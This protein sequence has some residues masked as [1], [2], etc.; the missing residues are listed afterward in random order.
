MSTFNFDVIVVGDSNV[1]KTTY[2]NR[3]ASG[4]FTNKPIKTT[5]KNLYPISFNVYS[6]KNK[7]IKNIIFNCWDLD[8]D[9]I[10]DHGGA[11][12]AIIM[13]DVTVPESYNELNFLYERMTKI[14]GDIAFV[15][16]GN[17]VD[18]KDRKVKAT[19]ISS[20]DNNNMKYYDISAKSNYNY[21]KPFLSLARE[22]TG[23]PDLVFRCSDVVTP[24]EVTLQQSPMLPPSESEIKAEVMK[25]IKL[26]FNFSE[27]QM[28]KYDLIFSRTSEKLSE[29]NK[30]FVVAIAHHEK[31]DVC[32]SSLDVKVFPNKKEYIEYRS[33]WLVDK[34]SCYE[35]NI[36]DCTKLMNMINAILEYNILSG[37]LIRYNVEKDCF[38]DFEDSNRP[39]AVI[40]FN[41]IDIVIHKNI[42]KICEETSIVEMMIK[43][44]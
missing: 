8:E 28:K 31:G 42:I 34:I 44:V 24:P 38:G 26:R 43:E 4:E 40:C 14:Y 7:H 3:L 12:G 39:E 19:N 18:L 16:C 30:K 35:E 17:K 13:F 36:E 5:N 11:E 29:E 32:S 22:F 41:D 20:V 21:E 23:D 6:P 15:L 37:K 10:K 25:N 2:L 1:G 9:M 33:I 27:E